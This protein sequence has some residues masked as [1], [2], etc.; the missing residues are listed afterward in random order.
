[1]SNLKIKVTLGNYN[2][3]LEG[4]SED[5]ISQ[6]KEIKDH[7]LGQIVD[8]FANIAQ[9]TPINLHNAG[10]SSKENLLVESQSTDDEHSLLDLASKDIISS[11][12]EWIIIYAYYI[13]NEGKTYFTRQDIIRKYEETNRKKQSAL[14]NLSVYIGLNQK[15][16]W[17]RKHNDTDYILLPAGI[18]KAQEILARTVGSAKSIRR[19][20]K[21]EKN[22]AETNTIS[23]SNEN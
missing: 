10:E 4:A 5:V 17:I 22:I 14:K 3:E 19:Q 23:N 2:I 1:M 15:Y 6:F 11:E 9:R 16:G 20:K 7:G 21:P 12:T 8:Q 18:T 13:K